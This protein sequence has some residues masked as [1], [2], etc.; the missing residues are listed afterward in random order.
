MDNMDNCVRHTEPDQVAHRQK[1][2][3]L[4][5]D[6]KTVQQQDRVKVLHNNRNTLE[7]RSPLGYRQRTP[8]YAVQGHSNCFHSVAL[9]SRQQSEKIND[10]LP[11]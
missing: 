6:R 9:E 3:R 4:V 1:L 7:K 8:R 11:D 5:L 10:L 2:I